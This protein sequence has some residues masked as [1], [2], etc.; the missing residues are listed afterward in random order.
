MCSLQRKPSPPSRSSTS[1]GSPWPCYRCSSQ[2]LC[3]YE[4]RKRKVK[5]LWT[6]SPKCP[7]TP[8]DISVS[9]TPGKVFGRWRPGEWH[10]ASWP[11]SQ[12]VHNRH[13]HRFFWMKL[14]ISLICV[15]FLIQLVD[16]VSISDC[17]FAWE[18]GGEPLLKK[19]FCLQTQY[20]LARKLQTLNLPLI[21]VPIFVIFPVC[22]WT[23]SQ[24]GWWQ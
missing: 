1:C 2:A 7:F 9:E 16:A 5:L 6:Q 12:Y 11:Q 15:V 23:L 21:I 19:Y 20:Y 8:S 17:S 18:R 4:G 10:R 14:F 22:L 13:F 3:R 24:G